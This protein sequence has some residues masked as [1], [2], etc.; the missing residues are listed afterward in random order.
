[1]EKEKKALESM[2]AKEKMVHLMDRLINV[3]DRIAKDENAEPEK[4]AL[5]PALMQ[6]IV[7]ITGY[8]VINE[9]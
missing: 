7:S 1:M 9:R 3:V 8:A 2:T 5:L 4:L 6:S